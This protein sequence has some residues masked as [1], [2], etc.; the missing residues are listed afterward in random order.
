MLNQELQ[1]SLEEERRTQRDHQ[2]FRRRFHQSGLIFGFG[3][4]AGDAM[5]A[6]AAVGSLRLPTPSRPSIPSLSSRLTPA[7]IWVERHVVQR[8]ESKRHKDF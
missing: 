3:C 1:K 5:A 6:A 2:L 4:I 7:P 8:K